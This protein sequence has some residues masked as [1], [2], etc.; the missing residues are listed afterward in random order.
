MDTGYLIEPLVPQSEGMRSAE[1]RDRQDLERTY[2]HNWRGADNS[3]GR[4]GFTD[5]F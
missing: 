4:K 2:I 1:E 3:S 5:G